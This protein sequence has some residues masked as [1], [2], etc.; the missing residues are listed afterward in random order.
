MGPPHAIGVKEIYQGTIWLAATR[1]C[2]NG[3]TK[4]LF[5]QGIVLFTFFS[6]EDTPRV[7]LIQF[8]RHPKFQPWQGIPSTKRAVLNKKE[9][10]DKVVAFWG[11]KMGSQVHSEKKKVRQ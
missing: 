8:S 10:G 11:G 3:L 1:F 5:P 9:T 4:A 2:K 7:N 6:H